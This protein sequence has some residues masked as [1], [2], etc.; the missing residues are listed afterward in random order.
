M[1]YQVEGRLLEVCNCE[2][3]C[4]CWIGEDADNG[5]CD[6]IVAYH[7]DQGT[8][9]GVDVSGRTLAIVPHIPGNIM[10]GNWKALI[11]VDDQATEAQQGALL[12]VFT[13]K[14]GGAIADMA[15]LIGEVVGV[16]R[17][18]VSFDV[19]GGEGRVKL[20]SIS[21]AELMPY[22]G[23]TGSA[24]ALHDTVFSTIPG[25]PAYVAKARSYTRNTS[26]YGLRDIDLVGHNAV[27]GTFR[28]E[29]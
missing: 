15:G 13:G 17:A 23:A 9:E 22:E 10:E 18:P 29:A 19:T 27:Q 12:N 4:P 21:E 1:A 20:G 26:Q 25:S 2:V 7:V 14:L 24:T 16:E 11:V 3:L 8:V 5:T 28:F 6:A